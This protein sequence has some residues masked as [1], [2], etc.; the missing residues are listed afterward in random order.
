M[1]I[2][3]VIRKKNGKLY[4]QYVAML[5]KYEGRKLLE[6]AKE[7]KIEDI[8]EKGHVWLKAENQSNTT[9][10]CG[11]DPVVS[12]RLHVSGEEWVRFKGLV[13]RERP[14]NL[15][16]LFSEFVKACLE[17]PGIVDAFCEGGADGAAFVKFVNVFLGSP[18]GKWER[19]LWSKRLRG[20]DFPGDREIKG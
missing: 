16:W 14:F 17:C 4:E 10:S 19:R 8:D 20:G 9:F 3:K 13:R 11:R 2:Y 12:F 7:F 1:K 18:R 5:S 15:C 6:I